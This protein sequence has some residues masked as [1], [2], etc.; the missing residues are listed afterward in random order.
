VH[1]A[2]IH[3]E[4]FRLFG[5][6]S[7][8]LCMPLHP[9]LNVLVGENDAG[10]SAIIDAVRL[11]LGTTAQDFLRV[12]DEDFHIENGV[13]ASE[14][15][16]RCLFKEIDKETGAALLEHLS[17]LDGKPCLYVNFRAA[18]NDEANPGDVSPWRCAP[19]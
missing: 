9:G 11:A 10:K 4:N 17:Y 1:L 19:P 6:G 18:R 16:I 5:A 7:A 13:R 8:G 14:F 15:Y 2:D 12:T 3:I